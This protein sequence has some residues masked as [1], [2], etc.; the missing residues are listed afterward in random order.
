MTASPAGFTPVE[1]NDNDPTTP[2]SAATMLEV[3]NVIATYAKTLVDAVPGGGVGGGL[4][5]QNT[6]PAAPSTMAGSF[7]WVQLSPGDTL[8]V[9]AVSLVTP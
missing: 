6:T 9:L 4:V 1:I 8:P 2:A 5:M 3:Q 7:L